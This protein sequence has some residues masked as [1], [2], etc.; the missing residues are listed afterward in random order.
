MVRSNS[1]R[2]DGEN[3]FVGVYDSLKIE[4]TSEKMLFSAL[5]TVY[6]SFNSDEAIEYRRI[7]SISEDSI[8]VVIQEFVEGME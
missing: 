2:E 8:G 7:H 6:Q 3:M 5:N 1:R 4:C